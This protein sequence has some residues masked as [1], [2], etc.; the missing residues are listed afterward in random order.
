MVCALALP[1]WAHD[2]HAHGGSAP[3][4]SGSCYAMKSAAT[5]RYIARERGDAYA[6]NAPRAAD[7]EPFR[8]QLTGVDRYLLLDTRGA[9]LAPGPMGGLTAGKDGSGR[10]DW[11]IEPQGD[12]TFTLAQPQ[13]S[14]MAAVNPRGGQVHMAAAAPEQVVTH[15]AAEN[16]VRCAKSPEISTSSRGRPTRGDTPFGEVSGLVDTH[17]H[18][19]TFEFVGGRLHCGRP[20]H[21]DGPAA[22]LVD[23]PDHYLA[24]GIGA[25]V[26]NFLSKRSP[27]GTHDP[28]GWPTFKDWPSYDTFTHEQ[29][30][31]KWIERSW[32]GGLRIMVNLFVE[33]EVL[34]D[35]YPLKKNPCDDMSSIRLQARDIYAMQKYIDSQHGGPGKGWFRIVTDPFQARRVINDGKLAVVLGIETSG[36]FGCNIL[37]DQPQCTAGDIDRGLDEVFDL[38]VRDMELINKFDNAF[39]G[40]AFDSGSTGAIVNAGN[41]LKTGQFWQAKTC[42]GPMHDNPLTPGLPEGR[43]QLLGA[44]LLLSNIPVGLV[45]A[46][47][48]APHCNV[49]GLTSLG[50]HVVNGMIDRGMIIDPDHLSVLARSEALTIIEKRGYSGVVS[51]HSWSDPE[52][53]ARILRA[54][55]VIGPYAG[56]S[57]N[58]VKE[59]KRVRKLRDPR[60]KFGLGYGVDMGGFGKQGAPRGEDVKNP[61]KY[62]FKSYDGSVTFDRQKSGERLFDINADGVAHYGMFP[63]W[64]EDIRQI[65]GRAPIRD[66]ANAAEAYLQ[67]WERASGVPY[68]DCLDGRGQLSGGGVGPVSL[69]QRVQPLLMSAG[70]PEARIG[71]GWRWCTTGKGG[72]VLAELAPGGAVELALSSA[73]GHRMKGIAPGDR[74]SGSG[75]RTSGRSGDGRVVYRVKGGKVTHVGV[76][77]KKLAKKGGRLEKAAEQALKA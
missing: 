10:G 60:Y 43:D 53:D 74:E 48:P 37:N 4:V 45:P 56:N 32:R 38:G 35:A 67:M 58:Y 30:Y 9:V 44:G 6:A 34:C 75:M 22:A 72:E 27:V 15:F 33:N 49:R 31:Y 36:P 63:D 57:T 50:E 71:R 62:P 7:A 17:M 41:R 28:I 61:V 23:C 24:N 12:G 25:V 21:P 51:S 54:G 8:V 11:A 59:W 64:V 46:Y 16:A 52:A 42:T 68:G 29:T 13:T 14:S 2:G 73:R 26:E 65:E 70:Q 66:M 69:G 47:P 39:G 40:V 19:M 77:T 76:A 20:W 1:A 55:G 3:V 18:G 5:G